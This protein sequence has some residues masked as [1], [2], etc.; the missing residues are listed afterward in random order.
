MRKDVFFWLITL[1]CTI[2]YTNYVYLVPI[3]PDFLLRKNVSLTIIGV[4]LSLYQFTNVLTAL[5][6]GKYLTYYRKTRIIL[7]GQILLVFTN[8][9]M[10]FLNYFENTDVIL[11][12]AAILRLAQGV[13]LAMVASTIYSYVP[14]LYPEDLDKKYAFMEIWTGLGLALGPVIAGFL[15]DSSG[16]TLSFVLVSIIYVAALLAVFPCMI[17]TE[18][19][20]ATKPME[21]RKYLSLWKMFKNCDFILTILVFGLS[22]MSYCVIQPDFSDHIHQYGGTD[23]TV[24]LIFGLGDLCYALT[25]FLM[26]ASLPK[27]E[28]MGVTHKHLFIFGGV[29]S[30]ISLLFIG[31]EPLTGLPEG[32]VVITIGMAILGCSQM[33]YV[34]ILIAEFMDIEKDIFGD[35]EGLEELASGLFMAAV[36][37]TQMVGGVIGGVLSE[38]LGFRRGM[39]VYAGMLGV[40]LVVYGVLRKYR[41]GD[42][43]GVEMERVL[44]E[45]GGE[46]KNDRK[47]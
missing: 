38:Y 23:E 32:L 1:L 12:L 16:Y 18:Y 8:V 29:L 33:F 30:L 13:S 7:F 41:K 9:L 37:G 44:M 21:N 39:T 4:L 26:M 11:V 25:G 17:R 36:A 10:G 3:L 31:P 14:V 34:P 43:N 19:A 35:G 24:G 28:R 6:L 27:L 45:E 20:N 40:Y 2:D 47:F 22:F 15:Y 46:E 5:Y 42:A